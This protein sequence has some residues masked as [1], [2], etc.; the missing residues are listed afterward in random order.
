MPNPKV[1]TVTFEVGRAVNE[2]KSGKVEYRVEKAGIIHAPL[3]KVSFDVEKLKGNLL[4]VMDALVKA[5]P[6]TAKGAYLRKV[7]IS[8]TMGPGINID[9]P[10]LQ[11]QVK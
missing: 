3:G 10:T 8:S 11:A 5:K 4:A 1:G 6:S 9:V 2:A 7:S